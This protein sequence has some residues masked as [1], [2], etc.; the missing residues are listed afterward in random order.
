MDV[1]SISLALARGLGLGLGLRPATRLDFFSAGLELGREGR[2]AGVS[3]T[4]AST[5]RF[6][7]GGRAVGHSA[8][9]GRPL[10]GRVVDVDG[11]DRVGTRRPR[12]EHVPAGPGRS[13]SALR[14]CLRMDR[15]AHSL[16]PK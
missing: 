15:G 7:V 1:T 6:G 16:I 12:L 10:P 9:A 3:S 2:G 13:P 8:P 14:L 5:V 11:V 4:D